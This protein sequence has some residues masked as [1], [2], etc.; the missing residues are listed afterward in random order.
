MGRHDRHGADSSPQP[1]PSNRSIS[2]KQKDSVILET[3][4]LDIP[5]RDKSSAEIR[6]NKYIKT[7]KRNKGCLSSL[8]SLIIVLI[9]FTCACFALLLTFAGKTESYDMDY[10]KVTV[11][12]SDSNMSSYENIALFGIDSQDNVIHERGSRSDS[13]IIASINKRTR[14][15]K[16]MSVYRDTYVSIDGEYDKVNAAYS[17]GGPEQAVN[18]LNRNLD[19]NI[20]EFVTINFK[21]L[22]D[23][24]DA[25]GGV[26]LTIQDETELDNLNA[27]IKNMNK[28]NGGDSDTFDSTG[29]YRF[30]GNQA[31]AYSRIRY[32]SGGDH[33][34]ASHQRLVLQGIMN[35]VKTHP[36]K[37][38][39]LLNTV[40]PQCK[41]SLS[42]SEIAKLG[43]FLMFYHVTDSQAYPFHSVDEK[44]QGIYYGFPITAVSNV[45]E[46]HEYLFGTKDYEPTGELGRISDR[47]EI[48]T[49]SLG[50]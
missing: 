4:T 28:I 48:I 47:I 38:P 29:T 24:V 17:Y 49:D 6:K 45:I 42:S 37:I 40:L 15:V 35:G 11:N 41:T 26:T 16:L 34:R 31:V 5:S 12:D 23:A 30:D 46:A 21:A 32:M 2:K 27:Y 22:A 7:G 20:T 8:I 19:L 18:T 43:I 3:G 44:Y 39:E 10:S 1:Q 36:W 13:I 50:Y 9:L 14:A 25:V 33:A